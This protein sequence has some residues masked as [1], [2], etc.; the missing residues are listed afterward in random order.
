M[1]ERGEGGGHKKKTALKTGKSNSD[2]Q[3][4][5][6]AQVLAALRCTLPHLFAIYAPTGHFTHTFLKYNPRAKFTLKLIK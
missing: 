6:K 4:L 2:S 1:G 5:R 3:I